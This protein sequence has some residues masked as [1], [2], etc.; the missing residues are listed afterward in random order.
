MSTETAWLAMRLEGP[1][2][3]WGFDSQYNRRSTGL[4]P[5][6]SAIA[7]MCCAALGADR[8]SA[9]E[10]QILAEFTD[11]KMTAI[12]IPRYVRGKQLEVRRLQDYHTVMNTRKADGSPKPCHI[13]HRQYLNDAAFGVLLEGNHPFL[14]RLAEGLRDPKWGLWL[15]R[16]TCI[17]A[18]PILVGF[19]GTREEALKPLL[20]DI[21]LE[22]FTHQE[23]AESF[24]AGRDSLPDRPISFL[25]SRR[26]FSPRRIKTEQGT[27]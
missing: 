10:G 1:L 25:A 9:E 2:Q 3:S 5:T 17:P 13:T 27:T 14:R 18:S 20:G 11:L 24:S 23:D 19:F 7:G 12:A 26:I 15:G 21:P 6:M 4:M 22:R 16:K 8:G